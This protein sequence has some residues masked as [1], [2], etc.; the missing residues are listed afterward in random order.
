MNA[1]ETMKNHMD[2]VRG[3]TGVNG[4][5]SMAMATDALKGFNGI[6]HIGY[7]IALNG[8]RNTGIYEGIG[9]RI[10]NK[11]GLVG[12]DDQVV[13]IN[14]TPNDSYTV[15]LFFANDF[16]WMRFYLNSAWTAWI[17]LGG[18]INPVLSAFRRLLPSRL[19]VAA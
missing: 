16:A 2:A 14:L 18:V 15:Q 17:K 13:I 9:G 11:A 1:S 4:L 19:E 6:K 10:S 5:L 12:N 8:F 7:M 3:V